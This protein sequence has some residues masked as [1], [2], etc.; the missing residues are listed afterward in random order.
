MLADANVIFDYNLR[1]IL[2]CLWL[3]GRI[4]LRVTS[5]I[6]DEAFRNILARSALPPA[7]IYRSRSRLEVALKDA[8]IEV[9][10]DLIPQIHLSDSGDRHALAAAIKGAVRQD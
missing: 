4:R 9:Y 8:F 7:I 2:V 6:M 3:A 1:D 10:Q 5:E